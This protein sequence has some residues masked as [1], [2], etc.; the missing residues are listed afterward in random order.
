[1]GLRLRNIGWTASLHPLVLAKVSLKSR[2]V[3]TER[4][5]GMMM[6]CPEAIAWCTK[7]E[8]GLGLGMTIQML[9]KVQSH[10]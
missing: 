2:A 9:L 10:L 7:W 1:M 3:H 4:D 5:S 6:P 8:R